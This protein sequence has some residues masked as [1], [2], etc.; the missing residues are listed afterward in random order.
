M[1]QQTRTATCLLK[2]LICLRWYIFQK[3]LLAWNFS[4]INKNCFFCQGDGYLWPHC[5]MNNLYISHRSLY[6]PTYSFWAIRSMLISLF[7]VTAWFDTVY[8]VV[9]R[10]MN[11]R[12]KNNCMDMNY[13]Y[14]STIFRSF[15]AQNVQISGKK[16]IFS[17]FA[18]EFF[19][20]KLKNCK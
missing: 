14:P 18:Y 9:T 12:K 16:Y 17:I 5:C 2:I 13:N 20:A 15:L 6:A 8:H 7:R 3:L 19:K 1:Q 10:W 4:F 11:F